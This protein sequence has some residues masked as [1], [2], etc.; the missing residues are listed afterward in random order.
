[1]KYSNT[2]QLPGPEKL[3]GPL[4]NR[5]LVDLAVLLDSYNLDSKGVG[6][7]RQLYCL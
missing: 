3:L 2:K 5:P 7:V 4:R 6:K 1:M